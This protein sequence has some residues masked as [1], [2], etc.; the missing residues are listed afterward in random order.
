MFVGKKKGF[1]STVISLVIFIAVAGVVVAIFRENE[2]TDM[3]GAYGYLKQKSIDTEQCY[4]QH[5]KNCIVLP[6]PEAVNDEIVKVESGQL[7]DD[8]LNYKGPKFGEAFLQDLAKLKKETTLS[9]L[10]KLEELKITD[11]KLNKKDWAHWAPISNENP[12]WTSKL[13]VLYNQAVPDSIEMEDKDLQKTND[14][15]KACKITKGEWIDPYSGKTIKDV[16][17]M[18]VDFVIP[19]SQI[20]NLGGKD[21]PN[22]KKKKY[23]NDTELVL[24]AI[25]KDSK[26]AKKDQTVETYL[27]KNKKYKCEYAKNY[28]MVLKQYELGVTKK[29]KEQLSKILVDCD[30]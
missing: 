25:S 3:K 28:T 6:T 10:D 30:K 2:I 7:S 22:E 11:N 13:E 23:A 26:K 18:T 1:M 9:I 16:N 5:G 14:K 17:E 27:P 20:N 8:E 12:C 4:R 19:L 15:N 29:E 21:W 24:L